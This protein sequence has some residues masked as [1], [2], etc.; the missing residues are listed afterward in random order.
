MSRLPP[1]ML[2]GCG[3]LGGPDCCLPVAVV[4]LDDE[5]ELALELAVAVRPGRYGA[6]V[7]VAGR[8]GAVARRQRVEELGQLRL[9][10]AADR[11]DAE[12]R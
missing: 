10:L 2:P 1:G 7:E 4:L 6:G 11:R 3:S 8:V 5:A 9:D 12:R